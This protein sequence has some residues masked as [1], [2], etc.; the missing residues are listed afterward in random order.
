MAK[1]SADERQA[2][3]ERRLSEWGVPPDAAVEALAAL[4]HRDASADVAIAHRL[5]GIA[6]EASAR[7]LAALEQGASDK[8]VRREAKRARYRLQQR[9]VAV[10]AAANPPPTPAAVLAAP[11]EAYVSPLD[12]RGDQLVWL[13]KPQAGGALHLFAVINDPDGL[14]EVAMHAVT[15]KALK[16]LRAE[17]EQAHEVRL[18]SVDWHYADFLV[19]RA[20]EWARASDTRMDGDYPALRAQF[21]RQPA[22]AE[23]PLAGLPP[24]GAAD[25]AALAASAELLGEPELRT[26]FRPIEELQPYLEGLA[27]VKDS[28]LVLNE[29]QQQERFDAIILDAV[30]AI[31]GGAARPAWARRL[32]DQAIYFAATRRP[33]RATQALAASAALAGERAPRD[34]PLC[35]HLVRASLAMAFQR[36]LEH[37]RTR[38]QSSLVLTPQQAAR[39]GER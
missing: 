18:V 2:D 11:I 6:S 20:F 10:A 36:A 22:P 8:Q 29:A 5:G 12:G 4:L 27:G 32:A 21:S 14:R 23:R 17:L 3:G 13:V 24:I 28:P 35:Q 38:E 16:A 25:A 30:D 31:F 37:E 26:W 39:R 33:L 15:R 9:G 7:V 34:V 1:P 19:R